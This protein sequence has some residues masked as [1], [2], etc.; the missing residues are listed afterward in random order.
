[1]SQT[2]DLY[3]GFD[4]HFFKPIPRSKAALD[5][6]AFLL[7]HADLINS[8]LQEP[9]ALLE[10]SS[11]YRLFDPL[12]KP[13]YKH[14][15]I[16]MK[17]KYS[18]TTKDYLNEKPTE[19]LLI[20]LD[21]LAQEAGV[22]LPGEQKNYLT[23]RVSRHLARLMFP[24]E[25][26]KGMNELVGITKKPQNE[27]CERFAKDLIRYI[28]TTSEKDN[29]DALETTA[30]QKFQS[31]VGSEG[32][33]VFKFWTLASYIHLNLTE[34]GLT[35]D[36]SARRIIA[37]ASSSY[38]QNRQIN[39]NFDLEHISRIDL[40]FGLI[41]EQNRSPLG[42]DQRMPTHLKMRLISRSVAEKIAQ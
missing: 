17:P 4:E 2:I 3:L 33:A 26:A 40:A 36:E 32:T 13:E 6:R 21:D 25:Y 19:G 39:S 22:S 41:F 1:M 38:D 5:Y 24:Q 30:A 18:S 14:T 37:W 27:F 42:Y 23:G 10:D 35:A 20:T 8:I 9:T 16:L 34:R 28:A 12:I 11:F 29:L 7:E 31:V 15:E